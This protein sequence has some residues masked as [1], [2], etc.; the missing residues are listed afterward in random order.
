M[1]EYFALLMQEKGIRA[2][3]VAKDTGITQAQLCDWKKGRYQ[4]KADKIFILARYFDVPMENF[5]TTKE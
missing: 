4:L 3:Q 1:Y 5:Y 2:S